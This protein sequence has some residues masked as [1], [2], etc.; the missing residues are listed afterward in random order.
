MIPI[1]ST[2]TRRAHHKP[3]A[4]FVEHLLD[5]DSEDP[6]MCRELVSDYLALQEG[7]VR[8]ETRHEAC[9][10]EIMAALSDPHED[11][12]R[13][14]VRRRK[15]RATVA[16]R[17]RS[18]LLLGTLGDLANHNLGRLPERA[19]VRG[20]SLAVMV[21]SLASGLI[22]VVTAATTA[23]GVFQFAGWVI[24]QL[25]LGLPPVLSD[26]I[27]LVAS[28]SV[29]LLVSGAIMDVK[30]RIRLHRFEKEHP[31]GTVGS[32]LAAFGVSQAARAVWGGRGEPDDAHDSRKTAAYHP[33]AFGVAVLLLFVA[34]DVYTNFT[35]A[36]T[37]FSV[38]HDRGRQLEPVTTTIDARLAPFRD[39]YASLAAD[40]AGRAEGEATRILAEEGDGGSYSQQAG[41]GPLYHAKSAL[42]FNAPVSWTYLEEGGSAYRRGLRGVLEPTKAWGPLSD[43]VRSVAE[44]AQ[45]EVD[46]ELAALD[47][48][49]A[50]LT[51]DRGITHLQA[52]IDAIVSGPEA[53][54]AKLAARDRKFEADLGA[55]VAHYQDG[56]AG[57]ADAAKTLGGY[58]VATSQVETIET[59][60]VELDTSPLDVQGLVV[61]EGFDL[62]F[63][64]FQ[65]NSAAGLA[66]TGLAVLLAFLFS[67]ADLLVAALFRL[68]ARWQR[69][70]DRWRVNDA[71]RAR[72]GASMASVLD[73]SLKR[74]THAEWLR[75]NTRHE[76]PREDVV[77]AVRHTADEHVL[78]ELVDRDRGYPGRLQ[79][80]ARDFGRTHRARQANLEFELVDH[81]YFR[82]QG[83]EATLRTLLTRLLGGD[84]FAEGQRSVPD[85]D[86]LRRRLDVALA[87]Q[88][89]AP[90]TEEVQRVTTLA[91]RP[92]D[93]E[94]ARAYAELLERLD[95]LETEH[96]DDGMGLAVRELRERFH[97]EL[98]AKLAVRG[99]HRYRQE[100]AQRLADRAQ[101]SR[102]AIARSAA[103]AL[104]ATEEGFDEAAATAREALDQGSALA[105]EI[106]RF[107]D[108][109]GAEHA[110]SLRPHA[111]DLLRTV[112]GYSEQLAD[113]AAEHRAAAQAREAELRERQRA[114]LQHWV[115]AR[116]EV[117]EDD[118]PERLLELLVAAQVL[119][120]HE[121]PQGRDLTLNEAQMRA[122][123]QGARQ[124]GRLADDRVA[125][126]I[127]LDVGTLMYRAKA[128]LVS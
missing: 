113:R 65:E 105:G 124:L 35:G 43:E 3:P 102:S 37:F 47:E 66:I 44:V 87:D 120:G 64:R 117:S 13:P 112:E 59:E 12:R 127:D 85:E 26:L 25:G 121:I 80:M 93:T 58:E 71:Y 38:Q 98:E 95:R 103:G 79:A 30:Q 92:G 51:A 40:A 73:E 46:V 8:D 96:A 91:A 90:L 14:D 125:E 116:P 52:Q 53:Q 86:D 49:L 16:L 110:H 48:S 28:V 111:D 68:Q 27:R 123:L 82:P 15:R 81:A 1:A 126:W 119:D 61:R 128:G 42:L 6:G 22:F 41:E 50:S 54:F 104:A 32:I 39:K 18:A 70:W 17:L 122:V 31:V 29:G 9:V 114:A 100:A 45:R 106:D 21:T 84:P 20:R 72:L 108:R 78:A 74:G 33:T 4:E 19:R 77:E 115:N 11:I 5:Q 34:I 118:R 24:H 97:Q 76:V 101:A 75:W 94:G 36:V 10:D 107:A 7:H 56:L 62:I 67:Y 2:E 57:I 60:P 63:Q 23:V 89:L 69:D 109:F 88:L 99:D 83:V 55:L